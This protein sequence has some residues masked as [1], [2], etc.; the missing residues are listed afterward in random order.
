[1]EK[2]KIGGGKTRSLRERPPKEIQEEERGAWRGQE[3]EDEDEEFRNE[4]ELIKTMAGG[5]QQ[6]QGYHSGYR[7]CESQRSKGCDCPLSSSSLPG[8]ALELRTLVA[9]LVNI[10]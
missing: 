6:R 1:M 10:L 9:H 3:D 5:G 2:T 8:D 7:T 4:N